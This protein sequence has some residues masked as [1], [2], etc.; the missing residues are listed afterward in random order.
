[1]TGKQSG[2][3][4]HMKK[5]ALDI[6][7]TYCIIHWRSLAVVTPYSSIKGLGNS[8]REREVRVREGFRV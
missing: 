1:M 7:A 3:A 4:A 6:G 5:E 8:P 2:I